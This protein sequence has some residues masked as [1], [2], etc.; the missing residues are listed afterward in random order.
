MSMKFA[1][2]K[3]RIAEYENQIREAKGQPFLDS[4]YEKES[5]PNR[6]TLAGK[7]GALAVLTIAVSQ[8]KGENQ[9][10]AAIANV[11]KPESTPP[12]P[13]PAPLGMNRA[14]AVKKYD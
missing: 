11:A 13:T 3:A 5:L 6:A 2:M 9:A 4:L 10:A 12:R 14:D 7:I 8:M 1:E